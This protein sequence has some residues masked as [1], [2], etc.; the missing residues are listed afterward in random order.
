MRQEEI[1]QGQSEEQQVTVVR[2]D[3][4]RNEPQP[5]DLEQFKQVGGGLTQYDGPNGNW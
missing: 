4:S 3:D 5:L 2:T 1:G